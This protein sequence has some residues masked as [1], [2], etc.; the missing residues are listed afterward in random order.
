MP[1]E[2]ATL[3]EEQRTTVQDLERENSLA[4]WQANI[5]GRPED[6]AKAAELQAQLMRCYSDSARYA[7]LKE[8][9]A[10]DYDL[11]RQQKLLVNRFTSNQMAPEVIDEIAKRD[12]EMDSLFN[13][14]R[15]KLR[16]EAVSDN[17]LRDILKDSDDSALRK[18]AWETSK[19][20]GAVSAPKI[21]EL[22]EIRNR[23]AKRLGFPDYYQMRIQLQELEVDTL[24]ALL[25]DVAKQTKPLF[26]AYKQNL[27]EQL[28]KRFGGRAEDMRPWHYAD[29]F[30][31]SPPNTEKVDIDVYFEGKGLEDITNRFFDSLGL[32]I[33]AIMA[34]SDLYEKP[35]KCQHAFCTHIGRDTGDIRVLCNLRPNAQWMKTLLHEFGHAA[36]DMELDPELPFFLKGAAHTM[37][38]ESIAEL[39]GRFSDNGVWLAKWAGV[40]PE[41]AGQIEKAAHAMHRAYML[42]FTQWVLVM[43]SFER[44]MYADPSQDLNTLW[45]DLVEK[46][47]QVRRP[48]NRHA[49]DWAAKIHLATVP[50]YYHNY[51]LGE[52]TAAQILHTLRTRV[53]S[54]E[55]ELVTSPKVGAWLTENIFRH[56]S[57]Y[58]WNDLLTR[59]TGEPLNAKYFVEDLA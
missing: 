51:L 6:E 55:E 27:D 21:L 45:W 40:R 30:F 50:G 22:V 33:K 59:A 4:G 29:P 54:S 16:G 19:Q 48:D 42:I 34:N 3:I 53:V 32:D 31:Q 56:G 36:Y 10:E 38:T 7:K 35:G 43:S 17:H 41:D 13:N 49:P 18:E 20:I 9:K 2:L 28:A 23:E 39:M 47:Q 1:T 44:A 12:A 8:L 25:D 46:F 24:F 11:A 52:M 57:R 26:T 14:F 15:G 58:S 37:T 5:T